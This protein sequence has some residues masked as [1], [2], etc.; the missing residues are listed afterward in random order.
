MCCF[1]VHHRARVPTNVSEVHGSM[2][3]YSFL[4][5]SHWILEGVT[6]SPYILGGHWILGLI[7]PG[8]SVIPRIQLPGVTE[9]YDTAI[10]SGKK[11]HTQWSTSTA[12][13]SG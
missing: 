2:I 9:T 6:V 5:G 11:D 1:C 4:L 8:G 12:V 13:H 7:D 10:L 3:L